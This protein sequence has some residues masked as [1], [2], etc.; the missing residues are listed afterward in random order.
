MVHWVSM[1]GMFRKHLCRH[2]VWLW[3]SVSTDVVLRE[4]REID[5]SLSLSLSLDYHAAMF[6]E[7]VILS[8]GCGEV[9]PPPLQ[10]T[11]YWLL[12]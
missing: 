6:G 2:F 3:H 8:D 10:D 9:D 7:Q 12:Y 4:R 11:S 1:K 5:R